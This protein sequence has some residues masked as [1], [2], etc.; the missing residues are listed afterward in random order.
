MPFAT[1]KPQ[2]HK[3]YQLN[4]CSL[5]CGLMNQNQFKTVWIEI[6]KSA[7]FKTSIKH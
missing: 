2:Y 3:F 7:K 4:K 6:L 1:H 5:K